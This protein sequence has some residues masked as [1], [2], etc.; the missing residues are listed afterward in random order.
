MRKWPTTRTREDVTT[1]IARKEV[2]N[3]V[4]RTRIRWV[5]VHFGTTALP[6]PF[7]N[8]LTVI[9][10]HADCNSS[11]QNSYTWSVMTGL[12]D[13]CDHDAVTRVLLECLSM[14]SESHLDV[15][16]PL[17]RVVSWPTPL[18]ANTSWIESSFNLSSRYCPAAS[19]G[20]NDSVCTQCAEDVFT[21][22]LPDSR[23]LW[24]RSD[25]R[26]SSRLVIMQCD[27]TDRAYH[28]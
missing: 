5:S 3:F 25:S 19:R 4:P 10:I 13:S 27:T 11:L 20:M 26:P 23:V 17:L 8:F 2:Q 16:D 6:C 9:V 14:S 18:L 21:R 1:C 12:P 28:S 24:H 22:M 15:S 7:L